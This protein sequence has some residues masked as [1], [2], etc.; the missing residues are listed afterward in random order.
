MHRG[1]RE[2]QRGLI[3]SI[4]RYNWAEAANLLTLN[5]DTPFLGTQ[6]KRLECS[7]LA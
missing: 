5:V 2:N 3:K 6:A 1:L 4:S 7:F